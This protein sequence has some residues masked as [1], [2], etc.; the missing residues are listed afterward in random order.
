[1]SS[2]FQR[3]KIFNIEAGCEEILKSKSSEVKFPLTEP[4]LDLIEKMKS[5]LYQ[6]EGVGL[7]AP[8]VGINLQIVAIYIPKSACLLRDNS[9]CYPMHVL[10]N[11]RYQG[12][13]SDGFSMD[14]EFCY[15]V[16]SKAGKVR[17]YNSIKLEY[18]DESGKSFSTI[19]TGFYGRVLQH[20]IDH[21][22]G[23]LIIDRLTP[24]CVHGGIDEMISQRR[25]EL[26]D[27]K[28]EIFD[29]IMKK[30]KLIKV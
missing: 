3:M 20:E 13:E 17:R 1:M 6:L 4:A 11:P 22:C 24:H 30:K 19:E 15:S 29:E 2:V 8:Q 28:K 26:S 9:K 16:S 7:A 5:E 12:I 14:Y 23:L 21:L 10:I 18:Q 25:G 27:D